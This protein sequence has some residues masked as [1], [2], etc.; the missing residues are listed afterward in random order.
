MELLNQMDGFDVLGKVSFELYLYK[1]IKKY[2][3]NNVSSPK[4]QSNIFPR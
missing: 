4:T 2:E 3:T 1:C